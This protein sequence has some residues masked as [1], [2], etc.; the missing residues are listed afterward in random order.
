M[1]ME[2]HMLLTHSILIN[3]CQ[4]DC[5]LKS[6]VHSLV[7]VEVEAVEVAVFA[8]KATGAAVEVAARDDELRSMVILPKVIPL[9]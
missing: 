7:H 5:I 6:L 1:Q 3:A 9:M 8:T 2:T 4:L